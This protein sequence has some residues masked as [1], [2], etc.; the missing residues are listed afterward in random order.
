[1]LLFVPVVSMDQFERFA[2]KLAFEGPRIESVLV[3]HG[4]RFVLSVA[5]REI[6]L[7]VDVYPVPHGHAK[8]IEFQVTFLADVGHVLPY[9]VVLSLPFFGS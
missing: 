6:R 2:T 9:D 3:Q 8:A 5:A 1:M 4:S 7:V